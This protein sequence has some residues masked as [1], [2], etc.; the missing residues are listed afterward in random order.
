MSVR[1]RY[2]KLAP[3]LVVSVAFTA[4]FAWSAHW[5]E[6]GDALGGV[7]LPWVLASAAVLYTEFVIRALRW[8]VLLSELA[9]R[10]RFSR[11]FVATVIGMALNVVLPF[12][13]GDVA[14]PWLGSRETGVPILALVTVAVI[15]RVFD[16]LGLLFVFLVMLF[17][18]PEHAAAE[19]ELVARLKLLGAVFG[20]CGLF[21]LGS[22]L[23]LA[24]RERAARGL[25]TG[26]VG[27]APMP[28]A[29]KLV[30]LFDGFV[31]GLSAVRDRRRLVLAAGLSMIH[32]TNGAISIWLL[33]HAFQIALPVAA[34]CFTTVAIALAAALPQA[35]GFFGVFHK[36][37][38]MTLVLWGQNAGPAQ[39]FAVLLWAVSFLPVATTGALLSWREGL[40]LKTIR[41]GELPSPAGQAETSAG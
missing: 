40:D 3:G 30:Q 7:I 13:A 12:R 38:E 28:I 39:A 26:M 19:G 11:L 27:Y 32:W 8:K 37:T 16:I 20:A 41:G 25:W 2:W 14:R 5:G 10:A 4:W 21:G 29:N 35:P 33:F 6:I 9:P 23:G 15:E 17:I 22:F 31:A 1:A 18:L 24:A 34:A 36:A